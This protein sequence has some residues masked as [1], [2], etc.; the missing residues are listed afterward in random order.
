MF[1]LSCSTCLW[2]LGEPPF[3]HLYNGGSNSANVRLARDH[4][5]EQGF[6]ITVV[7]Q[8]AAMIN[9]LVKTI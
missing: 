3:P 4:I 1:H 8:V 2:A 7:Q 6:S 5:C 9:Y